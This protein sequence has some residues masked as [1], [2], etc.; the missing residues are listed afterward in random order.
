MTQRNSVSSGVIHRSRVPRAFGSD[1]FAY[2]HRG[3]VSSATVAGELSAY[4]YDG[5]GNFTT[6]T[7][8]TV[9]NVYAAN[10]LNQ[11]E[12]VASGNTTVEPTYTSNG[13]LASFGPWTYYYDALSRLVA[14]YSNGTLVVSNRYDHLGRRVHKIAP[15]GIHTFLYDGWRPVVETVARASGGTDRIEY[16]WGKDLS[17]TI[18]GA[19]GVGGLLYVKRNGAI[20][21]PFYDA[22]GN[23][24]GYWDSSGAVVAEY[25]YDAFGRTVS[26]SGSLADTFAIRY[27]TKYYDVETGMYYYGKR[28]YMTSLCRWLTRDPIGVYGGANL[29]S[30]CKNESVDSVDP[31]GL[32]R[33]VLLYYSRENQTAFR[34]AAMT[35]KREIE[36]R[37]SFNPR[38]DEVIIKGVHKSVELEYVWNSVD[39]QTRGRG[40]V[41]KIKELHLFTHSGTP[42]LYLYNETYGHQQ[43]KK[44]PRLNWSDDGK[45]VCHGCNSAVWDGQGNSVAGSFAWGQEVSVEGQIGFST[46]SEKAEYRSFFT[47]VDEGSR[48]VYLWRY[49]QG[50][51]R[52]NSFGAAADPVVIKV[53]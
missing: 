46:F 13:E 10:E 25:V 18:D 3:E 14:A 9:T 34:R 38:C 39:S 28:Y 26:Q 37:F 2:N 20:F 50:G 31:Y 16:Y 42:G 41:Y 47:K 35:M 30:F 29:Y 12:T 52:E 44:L 5:I 23:I 27:S 22:F 15:D 4:A 1:R 33:W 43:I 7:G 24:M 6:V 40:D 8:G 11:Y 32:T 17:G 45:I 36:G 49:G 51:W 21:V 53:K 48:D 19:A